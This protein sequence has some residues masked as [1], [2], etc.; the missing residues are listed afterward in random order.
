MFEKVLCHWGAWLINELNNQTS[1]AEMDFRFV[2]PISIEE[3]NN[4]LSEEIYLLG[5]MDAILEIILAN[6]GVEFFDVSFSFL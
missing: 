5:R 4:Q 6:I 3:I 2:A 1:R